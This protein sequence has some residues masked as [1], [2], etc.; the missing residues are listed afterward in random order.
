MREAGELGTR[1]LSDIDT[2]P[3]GL[4]LIDDDFEIGD[5]IAGRYG[6]PLAV[7]SFVEGKEMGSTEGRGKT[8]GVDIISL[9]PSSER[10]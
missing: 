9:E 2:C 4:E 10:R 7:I 8:T 5:G 3:F 1:G 6:V